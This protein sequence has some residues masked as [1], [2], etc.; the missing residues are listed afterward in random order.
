M[1]ELFAFQQFSCKLIARTKYVSAV[2]I[3]YTPYSVV[4]LRRDDSFGL[5]V[6]KAIY[7]KRQGDN[8]VLN[9]N[10]RKKVETFQKI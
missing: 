7:F 8:N 4:R 5:Y 10:N 2:H 6:T 1:R 9:S 3:S